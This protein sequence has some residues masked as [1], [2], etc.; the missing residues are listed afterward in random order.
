MHTKMY[1]V[2]LAVWYSYLYAYDVWCEL[3]MYIKNS[4]IS[5]HLI[6][7]IGHPLA[8]GGSHITAHLVHEMWRRSVKWS[9]GSA[10]IGGGQG[11]ALLLENC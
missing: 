5:Y 7:V 11:M 6:I 1:N 3:A 2:A 10:Y 8:A 9:V 4:K